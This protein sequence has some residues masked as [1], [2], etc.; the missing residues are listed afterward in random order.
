MN[1]AGARIKNWA[2]L[3][4]RYAVSLRPAGAPIGRFVRVVSAL[5][6]AAARAGQFHPGQSSTAPRL[7]ERAK[8]VARPRKKGFHSFCGEQ[9]RDEIPSRR[10][11]MRRSDS[12]AAMRRTQ[13]KELGR[14]LGCARSSGG[15]TVTGFPAVPGRVWGLAGAVNWAVL[16]IVLWSLLWVESEYLSLHVNGRPAAPG[17]GG[18]AQRLL[19]AASA[20]I[21]VLRWLRPKMNSADW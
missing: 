13:G 12:G 2:E 7:K 21:F 10:R 11:Q 16:V 5:Q 17:C 3:I 1:R 19:L 18:D 9:N 6:P 15:K 20:L 4:K 8:S 14:A